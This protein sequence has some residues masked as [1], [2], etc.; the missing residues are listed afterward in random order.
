MNDA[1]PLVPMKIDAGRAAPFNSTTEQDTKLLPFTASGTGG[2]VNASKAALDGEIE[3]MTGAGRV[4]PLARAVRE[5]GR[6]FEFVPGPFPDTVIAAVPRNAVSAA[7]MLA[8][9]C[10]ALTKVVGRGEPFQLTTSPFA[11]PVPV[12]VSVKPTA[13]QYGVLL[14][15][16]VDAESDVMAGR[17][18]GNDTELDVFALDAGEATAT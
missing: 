3:L 16:V 2:P 12:T 8:V 1:I 9:S 17:L 18:I 5:N 15:E 7:V 10:V 13:L 6:E 11:K 14:D 4:V